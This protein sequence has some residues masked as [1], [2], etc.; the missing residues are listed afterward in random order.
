MFPSTP[1]RLLKL[2]LA[3]SSS[4]LSTLPGTRIRWN[5][6][7]HLDEEYLEI[8]TKE[9]KWESRGKREATVVMLMQL[10]CLP[11]C[12]S[13]S[14]QFSIA[15]TKERNESLR[16]LSEVQD[17]PTRRARRN[18]PLAF[19]CYLSCRSNVPLQTV[20]SEKLQKEPQQGAAPP[21]VLRMYWRILHGQSLA[22]PPRTPRERATLAKGGH[23]DGVTSWKQRP[24]NKPPTRSCDTLASRTGG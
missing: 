11:E 23:R 1:P 12:E 20:L 24:G 19:V 4:C 10:T 6:N 7:L 2:S 18:S 21:P 16:I 17:H 5:H 14:F 13:P 22:R 8:K 9:T 15:Q 3:F